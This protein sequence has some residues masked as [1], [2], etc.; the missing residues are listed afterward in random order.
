MVINKEFTSIM[1][2]N[3]MVIKLLLQNYKFG[4][5]K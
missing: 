5:I 3:L 1:E 4:L 2:I